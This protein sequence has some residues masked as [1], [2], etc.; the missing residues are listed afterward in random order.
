MKKYTLFYTIIENVNK[1]P[2]KIVICKKVKNTKGY[3]EL[4]QLFELGIIYS[5]GYEINN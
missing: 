5:F 3:K 1:Q 4:K 2:Y